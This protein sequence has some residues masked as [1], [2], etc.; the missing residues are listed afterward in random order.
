MQQAAPICGK[1][2]FA[3]TVSIGCAGWWWL[4]TDF[5]RNRSRQLVSTS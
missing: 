5:R 1:N 4:F 3:D 2:Y